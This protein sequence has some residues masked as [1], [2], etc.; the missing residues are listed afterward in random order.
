[1]HL[2]VEKRA[3]ARR[4]EPQRF[5]GQIQAMAN[6]AGLEMRVAVTAIAIRAGSAIQIGN[7]RERH[8]GIAGQSLP[9]A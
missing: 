8:A 1:M 5:S 4:A 7:H 6:G 2:I 9:Q 3:N